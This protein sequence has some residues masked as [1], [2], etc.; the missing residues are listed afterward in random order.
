M[1][2]YLVDE[3]SPIYLN[4]NQ[5]GNDTQV[6]FKYISYPLFFQIKK[7][8]KVKDL[9]DKVLKRIQKKNFFVTEKYKYLIKNNPEKRIFDLNII[10]GNDTKYEGFLNFLLWK[11][12]T[13]K[14]CWGS[15]TKKY[16]CSISGFISDYQALEEKFEKDKNPIIL[17]ATSECYNL[18]GRK[19]IYNNCPLFNINNKN[20]G[21]NLINKTTQEEISLKNCLE[22]FIS[23]ENIQED[24]SYFCSKC[25]KLQK[26]KLKLQ[27]Y[28]PPHYLIILLKRYDFNKN[29]GNMFYGEK[30]DTF[31]S[32]PTKDF[33]IREYIVGPEKNKAIY[34]LYGVIE[35]YGS[36]NQGH[37]TA[38]CKNNNKWINYNDSSLDINKNPVSKNAYVLFYKIQNNEEE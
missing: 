16:Y 28:K 5:N 20:T 13:C 18:T 15:N 8:E 31:V 4:F 23:N 10:H 29:Y 9:Y 37:Y 27:I 11:K 14:F 17:L 38:I 19:T 22:L 32:Y 35:H 34:D 33:D 25:K 2:L 24:D 21:N 7:D 1:F 12:E 36:M 30:N 3:R 6:Q 26:S